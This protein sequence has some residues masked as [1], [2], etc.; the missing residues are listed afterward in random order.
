MGINNLA[1][2]FLLIFGQETLAQNVDT[3]L[4]VKNGRRFKEFTINKGQ[5]LYSLS[6]ATGVPQDSL[7]A[8]NKELENGLKAGMRVCIPIPAE[9]QPKSASS[10]D[11]SLKHE[12]KPGETIFGIARMYGLTQ[13]ELISQNP[14]LKTGLKTGAILR[15][16]PKPGFS[17]VPD[18]PIKLSDSKLD[19]NN[20]SGCY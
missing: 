13:D 17:V 18:E 3:S 4:I 14:I 15:I 1:L 8:F 20:D 10:N 9:G 19:I 16:N 11:A 5:T 6:K 12:V 2:A 7:I